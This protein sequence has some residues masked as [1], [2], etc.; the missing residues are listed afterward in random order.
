MEEIKTPNYK[1]QIHDAVW[2]Q[3][4][5]ARVEDTAAD[6]DGRNIYLIQTANHR[7]FYAYE[8]DLEVYIG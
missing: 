7:Y 8:E 6:A 4:Q 1:F 2:Y 3:E 5:I